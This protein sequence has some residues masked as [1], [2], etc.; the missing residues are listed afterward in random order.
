MNYFPQV[1]PLEWPLSIYH[2]GTF[3]FDWCKN[4]P[5]K[6][7]VWF[8][9]SGFFWKLFAKER[10]PVFLTKWNRHFLERKSLGTL[11]QPFLDCAITIAF[12]SIWSLFEPARSGLWNFY[13]PLEVEIFQ[14]FLFW[15][16]L[17]IHFEFF[18]IGHQQEASIAFPSVEDLDGHP[19]KNNMLFST[20]L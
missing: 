4:Y 2:F 11:S 20:G 7:T 5:S 3:W 19:V 9:F 16:V 18:V 12:L 10:S 1:F 17:S 14:T 13:A 6:G 8:C 15:D